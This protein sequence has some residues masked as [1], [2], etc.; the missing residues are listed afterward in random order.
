MSASAGEDNVSNFLNTVY[1]EV[2]AGEEFE[3]KRG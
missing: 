1:G 2:F 3:I